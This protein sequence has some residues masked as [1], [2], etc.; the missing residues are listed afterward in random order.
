VRANEALLF[1]DLASMRQPLRQLSNL[2]PQGMRGFT[3]TQGLG[4]LDVLLSPG[5]RVDVLLVP[6]RDLSGHDGDG[7]TVLLAQN[8]LV[9]A[10]G[11]D[12]GDPAEPSG[13]AR[14]RSRSVTLSVTVPQSKTLAGAERQGALRLILRNPDDITLNDE[15]R[16]GD[17]AAATTVELDRKGL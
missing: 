6:G 8:L 15:P 9:L 3:L 4:A 12:L 7:A 16:H 10:V 13:T 5:D 1:T 2:V 11:Q 14:S 17:V